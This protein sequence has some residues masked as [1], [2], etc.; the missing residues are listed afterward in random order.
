[1]WNG[2]ART[3]DPIPHSHWRAFTTKRNTRERKKMRYI[4]KLAGE[5]NARADLPLPFIRF[6]HSV[7]VVDVCVCVCLVFFFLRLLF[8]TDRVV[9]FSCLQATH[10][11]HLY[12]F[13]HSMRAVDFLPFA[14]ESALTLSLGTQYARIELVGART[15]I[16]QP[17][18]LALCVFVL[19]GYII[20]N[21][22]CWIYRA[23]R[24]FIAIL[25]NAELNFIQLK[26]GKGLSIVVWWNQLLNVQ[27]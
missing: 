10:K 11:K 27:I 21:E 1:M 23:I 19:F 9:S 24:I 12:F 15:R 18:V 22:H 3:H 6:S 7:S 2:G 25:S 17:A 14:F 16:D 20:R 4:I 5:V 13:F 26:C 8:V